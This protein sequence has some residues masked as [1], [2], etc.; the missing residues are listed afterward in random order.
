V[1]DPIRQKTPWLRVAAVM[2]AWVAVQE[3]TPS[4]SAFG[5]GVLQPQTLL[6]QGCVAAAVALVLVLLYPDDA[7]TLF[8][9]SKATWLYLLVPI[10]VAVYVIRSGSGAD[11]L[12]TLW[13][14]TIA[15]TWRWFLF[16]MLQRRLGEW[17]SPTTVMLSSLSLLGSWLVFGVVAPTASDVTR[18]PLALLVVVLLATVLAIIPSALLRAQKNV[19][20]LIALNLVASTIGV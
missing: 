2:I 11:V 3:V 15:V 19:H 4:L 18:F 10:A 7:R 6:L 1:S 9:Y 14:A 17:L 5:A 12:E 16:G 13:W 8:A 20:A